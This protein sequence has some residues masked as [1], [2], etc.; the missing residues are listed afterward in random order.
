[1]LFKAYNDDKAKE[2]QAN[3]KREIEEELEKM[4]ILRSRSEQLL[5]TE[6]ASKL[7]LIT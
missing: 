5:D 6:A 3:D 7:S 4:D 2:D 1:M